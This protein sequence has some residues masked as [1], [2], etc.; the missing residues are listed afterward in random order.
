V[1]RQFYETISAPFRANP[2]RTRCLVEADKVL[3]AMVAGAYC[4]SLVWL[5][6][7]QD[8][9]LWRMLLVPAISA[10]AVSAL[11]AALDRPRPY[12][13]Y[14]IDPL[15][16][17]GTRG[18]SFPGR[19]VFSAAVIACAILYLNIGW[20][21]VAFFAMAAIAYVRVVGGVHFPRDVVVGATLGV[22]CGIVG[23]FLIP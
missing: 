10:A 2:T 17:K 13:I 11:R 9:R 12:E 1:Y 20:G 5:V 23:F 7:M 8:E 6:V 21:I 14:D 15:I 18:R 19:H 3:V 4:V 22:L 16:K